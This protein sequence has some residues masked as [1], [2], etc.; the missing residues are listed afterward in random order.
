MEVAVDRCSGAVEIGAR[1]NPFFCPAVGLMANARCRSSSSSDVGRMYF[2]LAV[3]VV[4]AVVVLLISLVLI[5]SFVCVVA[6]LVVVVV[7]AVAFASVTMLSIEFRSGN[8]AA[9]LSM[10]VLNIDVKLF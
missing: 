2:P 8:L 7:V 10:N 9:K 4:V 1:L 6:S 5:S 3:V